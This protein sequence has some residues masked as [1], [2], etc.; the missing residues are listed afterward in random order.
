MVDQG[1]LIGRELLGEPT[2]GR[3]SWG[4]PQEGRT[5]SILLSAGLGG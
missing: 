2:K 3:V 4:G 5:L 1:V